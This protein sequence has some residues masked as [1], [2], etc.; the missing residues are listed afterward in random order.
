MNGISTQLLLQM[1][2]LSQDH[3]ETKALLRELGGRV[4]VFNI[5]PVLRLCV[6]S[7]TPQNLR[8]QAAQ[9]AAALNPERAVAWLAQ[10]AQSNSTSNPQRCL[11]TAALADCFLPQKT[12]KVIEQLAAGKQNPVDVRLMAIKS[13][14]RYHNLRTLSVLL[15]LQMENDDRIAAAATCG[16][17]QLIASQ[18][19]AETAVQ[20]MIRLVDKLEADKNTYAA[21]K[22]L[23]TASSI[24]PRHAD[25]V[26]RQRRLRA[27][28]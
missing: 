24:L 25:V 20:N 19:G 14:V 11:A 23:E 17:D 12:L 4:D 10:I 2:P 26:Q 13:A 22:V 5:E 3:A 1:L 27:V 16:I 6:E 18:G 8:A 15:P 7:R 28:A 9:T 21:R